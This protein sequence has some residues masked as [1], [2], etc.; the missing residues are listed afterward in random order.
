[1]FKLTSLLLLLIL[2]SSS[3]P[4]QQPA[5]RD[6]E[7]EKAIWAELETIAPESVADF[8]AGTEAMDVGDFEKAAKL[9]AAVYQK[10]PEFDAALRRLG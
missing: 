10:A 6:M 5:S 8:K 1:M 4:A 9:Y 7:K 3:T 2:L